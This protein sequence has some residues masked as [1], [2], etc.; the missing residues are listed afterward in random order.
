[1]FELLTAYSVLGTIAG[2]LWLTLGRVL[3]VKSGV[4][5]LLVA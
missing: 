3:G 1:M 4:R 5:V 2:A